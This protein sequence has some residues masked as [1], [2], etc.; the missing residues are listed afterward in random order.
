MS[1]TKNENNKTGKVVP[2]DT[3]AKELSIDEA[4]EQLETIVK[5]MDDPKVSLEE[6]LKLYKQGVGILGSCGSKLNEIEKEIIVLT[7]EGEIPDG[8]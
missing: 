3:E 4:F 1:E 5:Q 8:N 6:S 2:K 7:E